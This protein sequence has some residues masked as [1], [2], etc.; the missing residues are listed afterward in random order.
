[1]G[2]FSCSARMPRLS[3]VHRGAGGSFSFFF[4]SSSFRWVWVDFEFELLEE[5]MGLGGE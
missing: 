3:E 1:M 5:K 4:F 2:I